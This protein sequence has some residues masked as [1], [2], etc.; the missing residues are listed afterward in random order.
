MTSSRKLVF[1]PTAS[2]SILVQLHSFRRQIQA[3]LSNATL[4]KTLGV[5]LNAVPANFSLTNGA[6]SRRFAANLDSVSHSDY[7]TAALLDRGVRVLIYVGANDWVCNWVRV[8]TT[9]D[10]VWDKAYLK[11][12]RRSWAMRK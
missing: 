4:R 3:Y 8:S 6:I 7:N 10:F 11:R 5:D 12:T 1:H 2:Y 9:T